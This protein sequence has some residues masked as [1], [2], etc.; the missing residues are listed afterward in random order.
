MNSCN[1][2]ARPS[3]MVAL[4]NNRKTSLCTTFHTGVGGGFNHFFK[5]TNYITLQ[6]ARE[7]QG[8]ETAFY[9]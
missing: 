1:E 8:G 6:C 4:N 5:F 3:A 2:T 9:S 7:N